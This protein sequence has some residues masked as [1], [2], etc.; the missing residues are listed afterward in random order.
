MSKRMCKQWAMF[1]IV[2]VLLMGCS[3]S[4]SGSSKETKEDQP[5]EFSI[6][7]NLHVAET[8]DAKLQNLLEEATNTKMKIQWVPDNTYEE[9]FN[10]ALA[11]GTLPEV[12]LIKPINF[13]QQKDAIRDGQ[14]WEIGPYLDEFPNL[15]KLKSE[16]LDNTLVDGKLYSLYAGRPLSRQG[17][18]YRKDWAERLGLEAPNNLD[19]LYKMMETFTLDDPDGNGKNDTI[20]LTDRGILGTFQNFATWHG[21]PNNWGE[22]DGQ[23][24]PEFMFPEY[25][26][27][28][29][30]FKDLFDHGYINKDAPVTSKTD[31]QNLLKNGTAGVYI[32]TMGDVITLY[33]DAK[34]LNPELEFDVHN[35]IEGPDGE[36]RTRAIPGYGSLLM[37]PKSA[38]K[39]EEQLRK[40]LSF[41]DYLMTPE[42]SNLLYWGVEGEHYEVI[43]GKASI[44][45][46]NLAAYDREIRPYTPF[47]IGEPETNGRYEGYFEYEPR[48][49]ADEL[50]YDNNNYLVH[51]PTVTLES[52]TFIKNSETLAQIMED[53][54]YKYF[55]GQIDDQGFDAAIEEWKKAGGE[56]VIEEF[57]AS[58]Q[59]SK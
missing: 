5:F 32:G 25:R 29:K 12:F 33:E 42:G 54:A 44:I 50:Y 2:L 31:Q 16:I 30:Y 51:D 15:G 17:L 26:E 41:F 57:N 20:G 45:Q 13:I 3:Q 55:L 37:F 40:I 18:I 27:A 21:A 7:L 22:K 58:Y 49:K 34:K 24:L 36:Y 6:M 14:Y 43:D 1:M 39:T 52:E 4:G 47:E 10:T 56:Q 46:S 35:Y 59:A 11:T 28:M 8:P 9:R 19:E 23:L 38:V 53:A 48:A